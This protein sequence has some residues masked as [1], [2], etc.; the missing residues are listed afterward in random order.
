MTATTMG[1]GRCF[2]FSGLDCCGKSTQINVLAET[3]EAEGKRPVIIWLRVGYTWTFNFLKRTLRSVL[4]GGVAPAGKTRQRDEFM[5]SR[6]KRRVWLFCAIVDLMVQC[7]IRIRWHRLRGHI[8]ICDRY[9]YDSE[10]D[11]QLNFAQ[12]R[13]TE[14]MLWK[15][16]TR[17]AAKPDIS[18]LLDIPFSESV[19]RS[20]LKSEPFAESDEQR[21]LRSEFYRAEQR[22]REWEVVDGMRP[23][24]DIREHIYVCVAGSR[25][26]P[27]L[28][29]RM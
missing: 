26:V 2:A 17:L 23:I 4:R 6:L 28:Q 20:V 8:V 9:L 14:W 11:L 12:D 15:L 25:G 5:Q 13:V 27:A 16:L 21:R 22:R 7:V 29:E 10:C 1:A 24:N 18:F 3:L 19:R